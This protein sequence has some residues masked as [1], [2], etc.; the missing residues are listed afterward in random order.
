[1]DD[2]PPLPASEVKTIQEIVGCLL[3]YARA[4]DSTMLPAVNAIGSSQAHP[5]RRVMDDVFRLLGYAASYP[6]NELVFT[7]SGMILHIQSDASHLSRPG[8]RGVAGGVHHLGN[9]NEPTMI[10]GPILVISSLIDVVTASASESEYA[11]CYIN[12]QKGEYHRTALQFLGYP[13]PPPTLL[14]TDNACA[15]GMANDT[16]KIKRSKAVDMRFHW[17]RDRIRQGH[18]C[19]QWRQGAHNLADFFTKPLPVYKHQAL[20][21]LLVHT[22]L[23]LNNKFHNKRARRANNRPLSASHSVSRV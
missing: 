6:K 22:P 16:V 19:V 23:D 15:V 21:P 13:Q 20:M 17:I 7:A 3:Y 4:V 10:N 8:S 9:L 1:M 2:S 14:L 12:G 18:F 5:T 11:A